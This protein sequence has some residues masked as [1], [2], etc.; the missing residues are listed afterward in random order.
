MASLQAQIAGYATGSLIRT[1]SHPIGKFRVIDQR[2]TQGDEVYP[3]VDDHSLHQF[4]RS[5]ATDQH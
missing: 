5:E 2:S 4:R 1:F 3:L